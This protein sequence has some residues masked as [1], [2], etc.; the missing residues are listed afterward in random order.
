MKKLLSIIITGL[1][2]FTGGETMAKEA[3]TKNEQNIVM[4]SAYTASGDLINLEKSIKKGLNEG[5]TVNEI[6]ETIVQ[7]YAYCG[8]PKSLNGLSTLMKV[9]ENGNYKEGEEG[10]PL[11]KGTDLNKIGTDNQTKLCGAPVKGK[12]FEF[13]PAIDAYLKEHLFG[14]IFARGVLSWKDREVATV[15]ALNSLGNVEPQLNAHIQVGKHNGLTDGQIEEIL[16][17]SSKAKLNIY[18]VGEPN[19][20]YAK[21]FIGNSYLEGLSKEQVGIANVTFE[22]K[23]RNNWHIHHGVNGKGGQILVVTSG[24]GYYQEWGKPAREL[25]TGDVVNIP[26]E[27]KHWHGAASDSWFSHLAIE[28]PGGGSTEWLEAVSDEEYNKLK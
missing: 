7:L 17:L 26:P 24:R 20:A 9:T 2:L 6:K 19:T 14:D 8:F 1:I 18:G 5:L 10:K 22:P 21:Y 25:K 27:V 13:A 15:A 11:P 23:C 3:L 16:T 12:L 4:I 28:V